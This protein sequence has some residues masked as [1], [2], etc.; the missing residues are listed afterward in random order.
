[1]RRWIGLFVVVVMVAVPTLAMHPG[2]EIVIPAAGRGNGAGGSLWVTSLNVLNPGTTDVEVT[3]AWLV[4]NNPNSTPQT[5]TRVVPAGSALVLDDAILDLFGMQSAGGA[6]LLTADSPIVAAAGIFNRAGGKEFGQGFEGMPTAVAIE[7]GQTTHTVGIANNGDYRTNFFIA[8]GS[9]NGTEVLVEV[10]DGDGVVVG[11]RTYTLGANEPIL[12]GVSDLVAGN[13]DSGM[14]RFTVN[15]GKAFVGSSRVN[16]GTGDPLTLSAW[17]Q[18]G[19]GGESSGYAP[20]SL[21]GLDLDMVVTPNECDTAPFT[22]DVHVSVT[23]DSEAVI[24]VYG[25]DLTIPITGYTV[26]G[27]IGYIETSLPDWQVTDTWLTMIWSSSTQGR[28]TGGAKDYD[29]SP[30]TFSG[31]FSV[32]AR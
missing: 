11:S 4:R 18:C 22:E 20:A 14:L 3:I 1:M 5:T 9:G 23:S 21:A 25:S 15:S 26:A 32:V 2:T 30:I 16:Q 8:D 12:K 28:F 7:A 17:W 19:G 10:V 31:T 6:F 29:G 13:V 27:D 24:T